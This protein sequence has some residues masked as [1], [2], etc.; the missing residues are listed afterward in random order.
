MTVVFVD[1]FPQA[2]AFKVLRL[3]QFLLSLAPTHLLQTS[4]LAHR[5]LWVFLCFLCIGLGVQCIMMGKLWRQELEAAGHIACRVRKQKYGFFF[6]FS[7]KDWAQSPVLGR[8]WA[9][10]KPFNFF[11]F[12]MRGQQDD[13]VV[14][15][16]CCTLLE[17][18]V[19]FVESHKGARELTIQISPLTSTHMLSP[20]R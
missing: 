5:L 9:T 4:S 13:L 17:T 18:W 3:G 20:N 11:F 8:C 16:A 1:L 10:K 2:Q 15:D 12:N 6:S 14:K 19:Q 7:T